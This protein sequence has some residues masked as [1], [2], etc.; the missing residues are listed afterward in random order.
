MNIIKTILGQ[1]GGDI[2]KGLS[3]NLGAETDSVE[4]SV[5]GAL[6]ALVGGLVNKVETKEGAGELFDLLINKEYDGSS[7]DNIK[8]LFKGNEGSSLLKNGL[9]VLPMILGGQSKMG[10]VLNIAGRLFGGGLNQSQSIFGMLAP[11]V[12]SF[13]GKKLRADNLSKQ[14][15]A[16]FLSDQKGSV[17]NSAAKEI[18]E[19]MGFAKWGDFSSEADE[20]DYD[21]EIETMDSSNSGGL[22][23]WLWP[24]L[25]IGSIA[26]LFL[27]T[28][29]CG[30]IPEEKQKAMDAKK[31]QQE[32]IANQQS[33]RA[34]TNKQI[35]N[36]PKNNNNAKPVTK[37]KPKAANQQ[38]PTAQNQKPVKPAQQT[39]PPRKNTIPPNKNQNQAN[40]EA[41]QN[42]NAT[43][44]KPNNVR[45]GIQNKPTTPPKTNTTKPANVVRPATKPVTRPATN[46]ATKPVTRPAANAS[47]NTQNA[48]NTEG[49]ATRPG[50]KQ[51]AGAK[52]K[53]RGSAGLFDTAVQ[54]KSG[55]V[56]NFGTVSKDN[57]T[58]TR[59][60]E[61]NFKKIAEILK[62]NPNTKISVRAHNPAFTDAAKLNSA[63][64]Q[65]ALRAKLLQKLLVSEGVQANRI[66]VENVGS[67][68]PLIKQDPANLRNQRISIKAN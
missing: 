47:S 1:Y 48:Q 55:M 39:K 25:V 27:L 67:K 41:N 46:A 34:E 54:S 60:A 13:L 10:T 14:G 22:P 64:Q 56:I 28:K 7:L 31:A 8:N 53:Y 68:E 51:P 5:K 12:L 17:S 36:K 2:I 49:N 42:N 35:T 63:K 29:A 40:N 45:Q 19:E 50:T 15:L 16:D 21:T 24:L 20:D 26:A 4:K 37:P 6:P 23:K 59:S 66:K 62:S 38:K 30:E 58:L 11:V 57:K 43:A 32:N 9:G 61:S 18:S 52:S 3:Q 65:G 44:N 33:Q